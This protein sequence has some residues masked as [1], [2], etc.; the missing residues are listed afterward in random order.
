MAVQVDAAASPGLLNVSPNTDL[1]FKVLLRLK[2]PRGEQESPFLV[3]HVA[4]LGIDTKVR[5][6]D[7]CASTYI[8]QITMKCLEFTGQWDGDRN[9]LTRE[10]GMVFPL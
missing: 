1:F 4:Q 2:K 5:K 3:L 6:Y 9:L 7:M 10:S 8:K